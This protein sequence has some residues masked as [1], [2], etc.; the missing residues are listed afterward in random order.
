MP[1]VLAKIASPDSGASGRRLS[2]EQLRRDILSSLQAIC[3]TRVGTMLSC[4]EYGLCCVGELVHGFPEAAETVVRSLKRSIAA[5]EPR[6]TG[7]RVRHVPSLDLIVHLDIEAQ[8]VFGKSK[9]AVQ[10][11]TTVSGATVS[12]R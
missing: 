9:T 5:Y 7:V 10:F 3:R 12:V 6:L 8:M 4:P 1:G 11:H 2:E